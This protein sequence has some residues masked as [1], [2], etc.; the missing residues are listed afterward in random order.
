MRGW[1]ECDAGGLWGTAIEGTDVAGAV[2]EN[3]SELP[4]VSI[5][6][7][8]RGRVIG[9]ILAHKEQPEADW[10]TDEVELMET[11]ATQ[12]DTALESARLYEDTQ[13][14]AT[15]DRLISEVAGRI[16]ETLDV[17]TVLRTAADEMYNA[18]GLS[19]VVIRLVDVTSDE[20]S[21]VGD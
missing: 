5:P 11:L 7:T 9:H 20:P 4:Q 10:T 16:R 15:R 17:N 21:K 18:L 3:E 1:S 8:A 14:R 6:L 13:D 19:E 12:L 2:G